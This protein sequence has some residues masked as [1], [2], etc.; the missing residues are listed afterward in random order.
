[1][2]SDTNISEKYATATF[3]LPDTFIH[4]NAWR[5]VPKDSDLAF[6]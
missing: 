3:T 6:G 1:M 4:Q 5:H 2:H